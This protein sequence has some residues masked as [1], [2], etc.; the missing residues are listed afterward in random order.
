M[1]SPF[2]GMDPYIEDVEWEDFHLTFNTVMRE[3]LQPTVRP[4]YIVRV[5]RRIYL[6][7]G[8]EEEDQQRVPD[9]A[10]LWTGQDAEL[11]G[12]RIQSATATAPV[13]CIIPSPQERRETYLVI[14]EAQTDR[15]IT[16][17][18]TL[19]PSN[20]RR[21]S[22]GRQQYLAKREEILSSKTN[23]VE[24]DLLRRGTRL[25]LLKC[26]PGDYFGIVSRSYRRPKASVY[27]WTLRQALPTI[28]IPLQRED[29]EAALDL[30]Q[31]FSTVYD[32]AD[33]GGSI[34]YNSQLRT[35]LNESD[36]QWR[37]TLIG[38]AS[39]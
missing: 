7:H 10:V 4:R 12:T 32:R 11:P 33:Y 6:E 2:P 16:V 34:D 21:S 15:L 9:L 24:L 29:P 19:S 13:E 30:Q 36:E 22:D 38:R 1:P 39:S 18:E 26:P 3:L 17:I 25:P 28:Q 14:R 5:E 27:A 8:I 31:A 20:K 23:L 35:P 37:K